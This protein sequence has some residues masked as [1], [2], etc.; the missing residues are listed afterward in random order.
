MIASV[1]YRRS[2]GDF[3]VMKGTYN[4]FTLRLGLR[5]H[6]EGMFKN[7]LRLDKEVSYFFYNLT[8]ELLGI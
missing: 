3:T 1:S 7:Q 4:Q 6:L 5:M 2:E 8:V